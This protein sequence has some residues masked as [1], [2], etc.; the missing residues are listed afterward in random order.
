MCCPFLKTIRPT[1][2]VGLAA[3]EMGKGPALAEVVPP[4]FL[5]VVKTIS[6]CWAESQVT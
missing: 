2:R 5:A 1:P 4:T 6:W 3:M